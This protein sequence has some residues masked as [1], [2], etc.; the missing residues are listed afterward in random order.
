MWPCIPVHSI[1]IVRLKQFQLAYTIK[2]IGI[3]KGDVLEIRKKKRRVISQLEMFRTYD[4]C[5]YSLQWTAFIQ[6]VSSVVF[7]CYFRF[8]SSEKRRRKSPSFFYLLQLVKRCYLCHPLT[9]WNNNPT[10]KSRDGSWVQTAEGFK[11]GGSGFENKSNENQME[12][13]KGITK[14]FNKRIE[15]L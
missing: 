2:Q 12:T 6:G 15:F 10:S 4:R 7:R 3:E 11:S 14:T 8:S 1:K 13:A 5:I 9:A